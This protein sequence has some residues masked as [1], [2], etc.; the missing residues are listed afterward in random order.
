MT[1]NLADYF[2]P[3][4]MNS[5]V[6]FFHASIVALWILGIY[7]IYFNNGAEFIEKHP[8][9]ITKKALTKDPNPSAKQVKICFP[10]MLFGGITGMAM[11]W[12]MDVPAPKF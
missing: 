8:G 7:W 6:L 2:N 10:L 1:S 9:L 3:G 4:A 11:M 12:I 5:I